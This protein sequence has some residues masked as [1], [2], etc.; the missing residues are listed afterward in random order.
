MADTK[1]KTIDH[2]TDEQVHELELQKLED[3]QK[4]AELR[5][6]DLQKG[7]PELEEAYNSTWY[8]D[9]YTITEGY[10]TRTTKNGTVVT[11][12]EMAGLSIRKVNGPTQILVTSGK[13]MDTIEQA[14]FIAVLNGGWKD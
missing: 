13:I 11:I 7:E 5:R 10:A 8:L 12:N 3:A 2:L 6:K 4:L 14:D 1:P 9:P